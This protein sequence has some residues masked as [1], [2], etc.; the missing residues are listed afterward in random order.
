MKKEL[1]PLAR[2]LRSE[3]TEA[4]KYLWQMLRYKSLGLK[5]RRQA[6][7]GRYI[8]DF[9]S[10]EKRLII[11]VDGGQHSDNHKDVSR[12]KWLREQ[13]FE[14]LRFWNHDVLGNLEGVYQRIEEYLNAP[15]PCP[16]PQNGGGGKR[17]NRGTIDD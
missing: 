9:V 7:I 11:E 16:S 14:V 2:E 6:V 15:L 13:G 3:P 8:V 1:T 10:Y 4:E 12:D 5:F 17:R